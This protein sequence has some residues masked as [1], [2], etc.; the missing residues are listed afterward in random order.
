VNSYELTFIIASEVGDEQVPTIMERVSQLVTSTGG[1]VVSTNLWGKRRL[2]YPIKKSREGT[3]VVMQL[4]L[5]PQAVSD[6]GRSLRLNED[7]I[8]HLLIKAGE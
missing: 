8:R 3:Y 2:A 6:L 5:Q 1:Q 4:Q 7:I